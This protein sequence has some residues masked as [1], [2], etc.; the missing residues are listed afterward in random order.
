MNEKKIKY[1][2]IVVAAL[3]VARRIYLIQ[4]AKPLQ[5]G[6]EDNKEIEPDTIQRALNRLIRGD[7]SVNKTPEETKEVGK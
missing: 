3:F 6:G 7:V 5:A 1:L 4:T 2:V